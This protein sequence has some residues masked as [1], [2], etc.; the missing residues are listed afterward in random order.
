MHISAIPRR[1]PV[2][3]FANHTPRA[4]EFQKTGK[5]HQTSA[6]FGPTGMAVPVMLPAGPAPSAKPAKPDVSAS[7][8][9]ST[10]GSVSYASSRADV[11]SQDES[12]PTSSELVAGEDSRN[13]FVDRMMTQTNLLVLPPSNPSYQ[14]AYFL[15][16]T[17]P[18]KEP[19]VKG[20]RSKRI[21]SAMRIFK[22]SSRRPSESLTAAH[23]RFVEKDCHFCAVLIS[24]RLNEVIS[25]EKEELELETQAT[26]KASH[27]SR[28]PLISPEPSLPEVVVPKISKTDQLSTDSLHDWVLGFEGA[29]TDTKPQEH[30]GPEALRGWPIKR[31]SQTLPHEETIRVLDRKIVAPVRPLFLGTKAR[32]EQLGADRHVRVIRGRTA[33][34]RS[35]PV[36]PGPVPS[37]AP[38]ALPENKASPVVADPVKAASLVQPS[39]RRL[40]DHPLVLQRTSSD[41]TGL[42]FSHLSQDGIRSVSNSPGPPPPRSPLRLSIPSESLGEMLG[43]STGGTSPERWA[44]DRTP[45]N[46]EQAIRVTKEAAV[47]YV[48]REE[49]DDDLPS[50]LRPGSSGTSSDVFC[51]NATQ[52]KTGSSK[53][54]ELI[55]A[56]VKASQQNTSRRRL[57]RARPEGPRPLDLGGSHLQGSI[58]R[59]Q[60]LDGYCTSPLS[61]KR[62]NSIGDLSENYRIIA[63]TASPSP[64]ISHVRKAPSARG[65][66][67]PIPRVK[68]TKRGRGPKS[69]TST[70]SRASSPS[71]KTRQSTTPELPSPP[72]QKELPPTPRAKSDRLSRME[73]TLGIGLA[74]TSSTRNLPAPPAGENGRSMMFPSPP[75]SAK[76]ARFKLQAGENS[77]LTIEARMEALERR[78]KL[79]EAALSAVLK[80]GGTLNGC[81][82]QASHAEGH[83]CQEAVASEP[84]VARGSVRSRVSSV[85]NGSSALDV[86]LNT[87]GK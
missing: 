67:S 52:S 79:L 10:G 53:P 55:D 54:L 48:D 64:R 37:I 3:P 42:R 82:C 65:R 7:E 83:D 63:T 77:P 41:V 18:V 78:N 13:P 6:M 86:Y 39:P 14:M 36:T 45:I 8:R 26:E 28:K 49:R 47:T 29:K 33:P 62:T 61:M 81:P 5:L 23:M 84:L 40:H 15:K 74:R 59:D 50:F 25:E 68:T 56:M 22:G 85:S 71:K 2:P 9:S 76:T 51:T 19:P 17:G 72:P 31:I 43:K 38:P 69:M 34:L 24:Y 30:E 44:R 66:D 75:S 27:T 70:P 12:R 60:R 32:T 73:A 58:E 20:A 35:H 21:S 80:T 11:K 87:R 57:R 16:T 4:F 1:R 46:E